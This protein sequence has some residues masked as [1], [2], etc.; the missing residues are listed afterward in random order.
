[1]TPEIFDNITLYNGDCMDYL[2][3]LPDNAFDLAI[4]DPPYGD[5]NFQNPSHLQR[6]M[7]RDGGGGST[8]TSDR[9]NRFGER[10]SR[11]KRAK[12]APC[13][14]GKVW[15]IQEANTPPH[16][17]HQI[18]NLLRKVFGGILRRARNTSRNYSVF[19]RTRLYGEEI[20]LRCLL[21][22]VS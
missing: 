22:D 21:Q 17:K 11:Y 20:T 3:A 14:H 5:G 16:T 1:M 13:A 12:S 15:E 8:D 4:V 19:P 18:I 6:V 7:N 10:F 2:R 9:W